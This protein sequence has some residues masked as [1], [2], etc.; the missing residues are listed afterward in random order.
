MPI[1]KKELE[2]SKPDEELLE[3]EEQNEDNLENTDDD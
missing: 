2:E 1:T 3:C